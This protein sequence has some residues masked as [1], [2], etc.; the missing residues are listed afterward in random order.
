MQDGRFWFQNKCNIAL[1][2]F[3]PSGGTYQQ[4]AAED[5]LP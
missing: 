2:I 5:L 4:F 1:R 3:R